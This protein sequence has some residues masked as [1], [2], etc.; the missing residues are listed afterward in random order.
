MFKV[1]YVQGGRQFKNDDSDD[2]VY[3]I[4][5][6]YDNENEQLQQYLSDPNFL[7]DYSMKSWQL[8]ICTI[9]AFTLLNCN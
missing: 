7:N 8:F 3:E 5:E 1:E 6:E 4:D 2:Y 9:R